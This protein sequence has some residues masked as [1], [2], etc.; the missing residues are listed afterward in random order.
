M[1]A[2][3]LIA[4]G[5]AALGGAALGLVTDDLQILAVALSLDAAGAAGASWVAG[6]GSASAVVLA[7]GLGAALVIWRRSRPPLGEPPHLRVAAGLPRLAL[8]LL[9]AAGAVLA[10]SRLASPGPHAPAAALLAGLA[11]AAALRGFVGARSAPRRLAV[12]MGG[13]PAMAL[14]VALAPRLGMGLVLWAAGLTLAVAVLPSGELD[15][16]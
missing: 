8:L 5:V 7:A 12:A 16:S 4:S 9:P 14:Q 13:Q 3:L 1:P 11:V 2:A 15:D 6:E 10:A